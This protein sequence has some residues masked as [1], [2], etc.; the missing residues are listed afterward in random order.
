MTES[1]PSCGSST[2]YDG[3]F[4]NTK[5]EG[6]GITTALLEQNGVRVFN[7]FQIDEVDVFLLGD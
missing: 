3:S 4:T 5:V 2:I 7:Q 1:S 6:L